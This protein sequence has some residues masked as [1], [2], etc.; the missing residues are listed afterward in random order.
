ML[1]KRQKRP[2][3]R[4]S[5]KVCSPGKS[6]WNLKCCDYRAV[7]FTYHYCNIG[8][9][10][11]KN[12]VLKSSHRCIWIVI[13]IYEKL[14][15]LHFNS[16]WNRFMSSI[17]L[18]NQRV[19]QIRW[20]GIFPMNELIPESQ[21]ASHQLF[22]ETNESIKSFG[23]AYFQWT[24]LFPK[25]TTC[26]TLIKKGSAF[27]NIEWYN[28]WAFLSLFDQP[29]FFLLYL[30]VSTRAVIGQFSGPYSPVRPAKI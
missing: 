28:S 24:N 3:S 12:Q 16:Q 9:L 10:N 22:C 8:S 25:A 11:T 2:V 1:L 27:R 26:K 30:L 21:P 19:H 18:R 15:K 5:R 29:Y 13:S 20:N 4:R 23:M 6:Q 7:L 14:I 17:V